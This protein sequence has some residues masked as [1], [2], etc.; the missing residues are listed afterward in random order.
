MRSG[1]GARISTAR[2]SAYARL[3]FVDRRADA[4]AGHGAGDEDD[5]AV[6]PRDAV[7]AVGE[8]VDRQLELG[9][10]GGTGARGRAGQ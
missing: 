8:G 2:A 5:V 9:A 10:A 1:D 6:E 7:A 3:D 4:V